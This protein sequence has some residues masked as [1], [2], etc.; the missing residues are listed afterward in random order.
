MEVELRFSAGI[1]EILNTAS[2]DDFSSNGDYEISLS[3][4]RKLLNKDLK[5]SYFY[6][7][8]TEEDIFSTFCGS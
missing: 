3:V 5:E 2:Q 1:A 6:S 7:N 4:C 8:M